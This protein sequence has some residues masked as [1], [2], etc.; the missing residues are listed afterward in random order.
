M[1]DKYTNQPDEDVMTILDWGLNTL[2]DMY[3]GPQMRVSPEGTVP[4][5]TGNKKP[6]K[7][8]KTK[9][10]GKKGKTTKKGK[11]T[12]KKGK[13]MRRSYSR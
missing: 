10:K 6:K 7:G 4:F 11:K 5:G 3:E 8:K 2:L 12:K 13:T 1:L 9:K